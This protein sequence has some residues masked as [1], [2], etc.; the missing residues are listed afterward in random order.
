MGLQVTHLHWL[1]VTII[2]SNSN[3][4]LKLETT[5][6]NHRLI[7]ITSIIK[8]ILG[9]SDVNIVKKC[10]K[11]IYCVFQCIRHFFTFKIF[12]KIT[13][14]LI[15]RRLPPFPVQVHSESATVS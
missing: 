5:I 11:I 6:K 4:N 3:Y 14:H 7:I 2:I 10:E 12:L 9:V 8:T 1:F 13:V 15:Q